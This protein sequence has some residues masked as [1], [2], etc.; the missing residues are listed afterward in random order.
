MT[1]HIC[2]KPSCVDDCMPGIDPIKL[3]TTPAPV[4]ASE[5]RYREAIDALIYAI[6]HPESNQQFALDAGRQA[7]SIPSGNAALGSLRTALLVAK[8][9]LCQLRCSFPRNS[10]GYQDAAY[11]IDQCERAL[12]GSASQDSSASGVSTFSIP[13]STRDWMSEV[14]Q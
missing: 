8:R 11:A 6:E 13:P 2:A 10:V 12:G 14:H 5:T 3:D 9:T 1:C 7:L 4:A